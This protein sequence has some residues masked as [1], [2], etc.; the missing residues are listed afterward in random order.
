MAYLSNAKGHF[1]AFGGKKFFS[2]PC[3]VEEWLLPGEKLSSVCETD[4]GRDSK[5]AA[6]PHPA[7]RATFPQGGRLLLPGT[8]Q[9]RPVGFP[10]GLWRLFGLQ[11]RFHRREDFIYESFKTVQV[12]AGHLIRAGNTCDG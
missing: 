1:S 2:Y 3:R 8:N 4:E 11:F 9:N 12:E 6:S 5:L 10:T 7:L